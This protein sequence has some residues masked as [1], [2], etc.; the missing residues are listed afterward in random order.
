MKPLQ[1]NKLQEFLERFEYFKSGEFR[2]LEV[3]NAT[4][5]HATFALQDKSREYDWI[6]LKLEFN[7][8]YDAALPQMD[9]LAFIDMEDGV[10]LLFEDNKIAFGVGEYTTFLAVKNALPYL[11]CR[12]IKY[13]ESSF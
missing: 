12:T 11:Y 3:A 4:S 8:V 5:I 9:K 13:Q 7:G 10:T 2:S 1:V 6:T